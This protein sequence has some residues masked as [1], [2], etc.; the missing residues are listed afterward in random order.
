[1]LLT[2]SSMLSGRL[3]NDR[4]RVLNNLTEVKH[5]QL[6]QA[7][8]IIPQKTQNIMHER[9]RKICAYLRTLSSADAAT[10]L[11]ENYPIEEPGDYEA[12]IF[13]PHRSWKRADQIRLARH[14]LSNIPFA[15]S[16][17]YDAFLTFMSV[18]LF[19]KII[20][21]NMPPSERHDLLH[22]YLT[23]SFRKYVRTDKDRAA[24]KQLLEELGRPREGRLLRLLR[25][26]GR[27]SGTRWN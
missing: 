3:L 5:P 20:R 21:E 13:I 6:H 2:I 12:I 8:K 27:L 23:G 4:S 14:Y 24:A 9:H 10:W 22:Y 26:V 18:P 25:R 17:G 1:M 19:I 7:H 16:R 11:L 15:N